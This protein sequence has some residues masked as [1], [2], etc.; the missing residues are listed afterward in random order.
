MS[1][2]I[3][4]LNQE[5]IDSKYQI[6]N[7]I[8]H[9]LERSGMYVGS[10]FADVIEYYLYKPSENKIVKTPNVGYFAALIKLI[11]EVITN[12]VDEHRRWGN[13]ALF[14]ITQIN[15]SI[16]SD[17]TV[18]IFDNGG[19][20]TK[21][22]SNGMYVPEMIF[23]HLRTS[24]NYD[25]SKQRVGAGTNGLGSKLTNIFSKEFEV[26]TADGKNQLAITWKDNMHVMSTPVIT[27]SSEHFTKTKFKLDLER[28]DISDIPLSVMRIVQ[29][30]C[31]DA[32]AA[33]PGLIINF[34]SNLVDGKLNSEWQF[35]SFREY[36]SLYFPEKDFSS[37][38]EYISTS[39]R[40]NIL[41]TT[42]IGFNF[43]FVNGA[44]CSKGTH[45]KKITKQINEKILEICKKKDMELITEK[46]ISNRISIF[47]STTIYNPTY[48][49]QVKDE[50]TNKI[51]VNRLNLSKEFLNALEDS[52]IMLQ[53]EEYYKIKYEAEVKKNLRKLNGILKSTK[54]KKLIKC[55]SSNTL[56]NELWIFEGN[57]ASNGFRSKANPQIQAAYL[58]RGKIMNAFN[59]SKEEILENI[60]LREIIAA[61]GLQ[62]NSPKENIK[63]FKWSKVIFATDM[64]YDGN[65]IC[66][67]LIAFF[68]KHFPEIV[69]A[70][71]LYR[72]LSPI[73]IASNEKIKKYYWSMQEYE[74]A[75]TTGELNRFETIFNKGLGG[76][77]DD[78][79]SIMLHQQKLI[80]FTL[81]DGL[82]LKSIDVW[83]DKATEQRK[84]LI[85]EDQEIVD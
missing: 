64:D 4:I 9:I 26:I 28:F 45:M 3:E 58:L 75:K 1:E 62:F 17:G 8:D 46:D 82:D 66:G 11:D 5:D 78:D 41:L 6:K 14:H 30:K 13:D 19:I 31:I 44:I 59:L 38:M 18:V 63:N 57:S 68:T 50:L 55:T 27:K 83:F 39:K 10:Q 25:D 51:D 42:N 79:Y 65:H 40:D 15:V 48:D 74:A 2:N 85:M 29:R 71:K 84:A 52:E 34:E 43:G 24:S 69:K 77:E 67:L 70:R 76:L 23:G 21:K 35:S 56:T 81:E 32:A 53:L 54:T 16:N 61:C 72:A 12:S 36:V 80:L 47:V 33:N 37:S 7:E 22:H 49:S 60:E 73:V 20:T